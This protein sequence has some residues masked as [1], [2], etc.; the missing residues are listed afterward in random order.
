M[1]SKKK[2]TKII[3]GIIVISIAL[4][5][6]ERFERAIANEAT[7]E[8]ME[9]PLLKTEWQ[10]VSWTEKQPLTK[11]NSTVMFEK[12]RLSGSG[13]CNRYTA[14]YAVQ[15]NAMKVGLIAATRM[16]CPEEIMNQEMT[17]LSQLLR[18]VL[19]L[20]CSVKISFL[21]FLS[22]HFNTAK[23]SIIKLI[24]L[25]TVILLCLLHEIQTSLGSLT[26]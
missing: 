24:L 23:S 15:E 11:E 10:L 13:S 16:A 6:G 8:S 4:V 21:F 25:S 5:Y 7:S 20:S 2:I 9:N 14:G 19:G 12:D 26:T 18:S 1:S 17:F 3:Q 22:F